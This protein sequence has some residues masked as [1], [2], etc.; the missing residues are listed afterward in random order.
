MLQ[1]AIQS[2]P[3]DS[4]VRPRVWPE[5]V[6]VWSRRGPIQTWTARC[7][8]SAH[9]WHKVCVPLHEHLLSAHWG[10]RKGYATVSHGIILTVIT[11]LQFALLKLCLLSRQ[12][13]VLLCLVYSPIKYSILSCVFIQ[14]LG[15][16]VREKGC[17][18][19]PIKCSQNRFRYV[20][21]RSEATVT[22]YDFEPAET[23]WT[24]ANTMLCST[25][26]TSGI[27]IVIRMPGV[28][29]CLLVIF[30]SKL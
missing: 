9:K 18:V 2:R 30:K 19:T 11:C 27:P 3:R 16:M 22:F 21:K 26:Y 17:S 28:F 6:R 4:P 24:S 7:T 1:S 5:R 20:I 10:A 13:I 15:R 14:V 25:K 12:C 23:E 8:A 29:I